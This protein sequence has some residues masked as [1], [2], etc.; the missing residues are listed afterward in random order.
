MRL[1]DGE[2]YL[3]E[4]FEFINKHIQELRRMVENT[5]IYQKLL[6]NEW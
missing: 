6:F 2:F 1:P 5:A 3:I 4:I